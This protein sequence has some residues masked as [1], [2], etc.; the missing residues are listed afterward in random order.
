V[1]YKDKKKQ[2]EFQKEW[3]RE[4]RRKFF[5]GKKCDICGSTKNLRLHHKD[6]NKKVDHRIWSWAPERFTREIKKCVARCEKCHQKQHGEE[7]SND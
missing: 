1:P 3:I 6:P 4:R 5:E 2:Q 7:R